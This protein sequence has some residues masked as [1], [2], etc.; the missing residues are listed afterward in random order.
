[1]KI[2][3]TKGSYDQTPDYEIRNSTIAMLI[4]E[5]SYVWMFGTSGVTRVSK[6]TW[7]TILSSIRGQCG[8]L[9]GPCGHCPDLRVVVFSQGALLP[10]FP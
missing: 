5:R 8:T 10:Q 4:F 1:M 6:R 3:A 7:S 2:P 9:V